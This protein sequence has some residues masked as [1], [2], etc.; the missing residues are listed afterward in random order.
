MAI[1]WALDNFSVDGR[2]HTN[3]HG[4]GAAATNVN[5]SD[6]RTHDSSEKLCCPNARKRRTLLPAPPTTRTPTT[7]ETSHTTRAIEP[8]ART[9]PPPTGTVPGSRNIQTPER[10]VGANNK[11][12][13]AKS[14]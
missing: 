7:P 8:P 10:G 9:P 6:T 1:N 2:L 13:T 12:E 14:Q 4:T 3:I 11:K 5:S